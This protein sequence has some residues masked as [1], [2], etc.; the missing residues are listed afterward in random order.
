[1]Q[2]II[3]GGGC[4]WCTES[5]FLAVKGVISVT[6][7]YAGGQAETA[8]Y[9]SVCSGQTGHVEVIKV[10]YDEQ[11]ID[12]SNILDIFFATHDPTT[13]NRQGNDIG[14][15]YASVIFYTD[16]ADL[17]IINDKIATLK[18]DGINV[19]TRVEKAPAFYPAEDYHQNFFAKNPTQGYCNFAIPPKLQKLR[20]G[21]STLLK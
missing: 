19:V 11:V 8:D 1:M 21:F 15:Q 5:V 10:V 7:G 6:S 17:P 9:E 2:E 4:F 14:T 20:A 13:P 18:A 3:L 12:L 16:E